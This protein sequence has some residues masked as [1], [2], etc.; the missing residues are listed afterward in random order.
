MRALLLLALAACGGGEI[1][2]GDEVEASAEAPALE[3]LNDGWTAEADDG[4]GHA[5]EFDDGEYRFYG[6]SDLGGEPTQTGTASIETRGVDNF[7]TVDA[8]IL[9]SSTGNEEVNVFIEFS[10]TAMQLSAYRGGDRYLDFVRVSA[11]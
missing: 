10:G 7:G 11:P 8:L 2:D 6:Y 5:V 9:T 3:E 4:D 1:A